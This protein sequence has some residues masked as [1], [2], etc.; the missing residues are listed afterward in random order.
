MSVTFDP[1]LTESNS[2]RLDFINEHKKSLVLRNELPENYNAMLEIGYEHYLF[3][4]GWTADLLIVEEWKVSKRV[5]A[6]DS[7]N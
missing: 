2:L 6:Q 4:L 1:D 3:G 5:V 7:G